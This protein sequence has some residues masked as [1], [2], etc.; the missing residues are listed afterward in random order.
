MK[1][2]KVRIELEIELKFYEQCMKY[3]QEHNISSNELVELS[4]KEYLEKI[5]GKDSKS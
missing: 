1:D 4:I 5:N 2:G 3:C